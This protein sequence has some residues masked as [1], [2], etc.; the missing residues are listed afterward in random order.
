MQTLKSA[1]DELRTVLS[2]NKLSQITDAQASNAGPD[3]HWSK[4]QI[5]GH[6]LDSAANNHHRFVRGLIQ[7]TVAMP[8][9][10][11]NLWAAAGRYQER[12]WTELVAWW[13]AYNR[14]LLHMM[15]AVPADRLATECR[16]GDGEAVTLEFLM[17][18][19][20]DHLKHHLGQIVSS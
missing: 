19:Y 5:L 8:G 1:A 18:D 20:V 9:Y 2:S 6:L 14:H 13:S 4:K 16:I 17:V 3:G 12:P 10:E 11:Q 15:E 7:S